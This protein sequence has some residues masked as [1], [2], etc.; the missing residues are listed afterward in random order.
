MRSQHNRKLVS[1]ALAAL[2]SIGFAGCQRTQFP[3]NPFAGKLSTLPK[4]NFGNLKAPRIQPIGGKLPGL[5]QLP[6][7]NFSNLK[8]TIQTPA[9]Q[10]IASQSSQPPLAPSRTF[11]TSS[12][13]RQ[14]AAGKMP[15]D[16]KSSL[17]RAR[18]AAEASRDA[19]TPNQNDFNSAVAGTKPPKSE[20]LFSKIKT[21]P[22]QSTASAGSGSRHKNLWGNYKPD[23]SPSSSNRSSGGLAELA[24]V[25]PRLYDRYGKLT[26]G[27]GS[28]SQF[29]A[30]NAE[31]DFD[32]QPANGSSTKIAK[33]TRNTTDKVSSDDSD[34]TIAGLR[35]QLMEL[36]SR[37]AG[38]SDQLNIPHRSAFD[39]AGIAPAKPVVVEPE[40]PVHRG[41]GNAASFGDRSERIQTVSIPDPTAPTN[42]LRAAAPP[43]PG[44]VATH[45]IKSNSDSAS[46]NTLAEDLP[47]G[48]KLSSKR[49]SLKNMASQTESMVNNDFVGSL[50]TGSTNDADEDAFPML[51][52]EATEQVQSMELPRQ[53]SQA[54]LDA[55]EQAKEEKLS[56]PL[57]KINKDTGPLLG[58]FQNP[59]VASSKFQPPTTPPAQTVQQRSSAFPAHFQSQTP[60][61]QQQVTSNQFFNRAAKEAPA[62]KGTQSTPRVAE[63]Q[64]LPPNLPEGITT[65]DGSYSPG[66]VRSLEKKLW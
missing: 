57:P 13:D 16:V 11:D 59:K 62:K 60:A 32:F 20:D 61:R 55:L 21:K 14:I 54:S 1:A 33:A 15:A 48:N 24:K 31:R 9:S 66:S 34:A 36:R 40:L 2:L 27:K 12:A 26:S 17:D 29:V 35:S 18:K 51:R 4:P 23:V 6:R 41:F 37:G 64:L 25:N 58:G 53:L 42:I 43:T 10:A 47:V 39:I 5:P 22:S 56:Q 49:K 63:A 7:P 45:E 19:L 3:S 50:N 8:R 52:A 46:S 28:G 30:T 44:M 65:G 38:T